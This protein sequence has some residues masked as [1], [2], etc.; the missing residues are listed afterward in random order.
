MG[1]LPGSSP[2]PTIMP[3]GRRTAMPIWAGARWSP[4]SA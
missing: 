2:Q 3:G 4:R 1:H